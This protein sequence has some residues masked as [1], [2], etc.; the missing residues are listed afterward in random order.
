MGTRNTKEI[1]DELEKIAVKRVK[2][3]KRFYIHVMVYSIGM[4]IFIMREYFN[5]PLNFPPLHYLNRLLM[6]I[7]TFI[8]AVQRLKLFMREIVFGKNWE[9]KQVDKMLESE[10]K[11]TNKK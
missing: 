6:S 3:I 11:N 5:A 8:I 9:N 10:S 4:V 1:Q 2:R 7:W